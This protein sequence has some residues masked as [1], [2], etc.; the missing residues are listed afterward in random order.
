MNDDFHS[1]SQQTKGR[2]TK[3]LFEKKETTAMRSSPPRFR[4]SSSLRLPAASAED[5]LL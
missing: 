5:G 2:T 3:F 4:P 1:V